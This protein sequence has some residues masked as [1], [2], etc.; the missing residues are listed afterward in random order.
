MVEATIHSCLSHT[1]QILCC[2]STQKT[3]DTSTSNV[4]SPSSIGFHTSGRRLISGELIEYLSKLSNF[5]NLKSI[6]TPQQNFLKVKL[7]AQGFADVH[8]STSLD[9]Y[10]C[11]ALPTPV[12]FSLH[13]PGQPRSADLMLLSKWHS[14][15]VKLLLYHMQFKWNRNN[16]PYLKCSIALP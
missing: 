11:K 4:H 16:S 1:Q 5:Y 6:L 3:L 15:G 2:C 7:S 12:C 10:F 13:S 8:E 9:F 14:N